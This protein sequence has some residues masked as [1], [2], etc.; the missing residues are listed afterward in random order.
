MAVFAVYIE[1]EVKYFGQARPIGNTYHYQTLPGQA[2]NDAGVVAEVVA[3]EKAILPSSV[4]FREARTWGP[5][6][7]EAFDNV[8]RETIPLS[9]VGAFTEPTSLYREAC[10]L[11]VWPLPRSPVTNRR[12]WLR[13]FMRLAVASTSMSPSV[14]AG[15]DPIPETQRQYLIDT[16]ADA[17]TEVGGVET[18]GLCTADG[19]EP[20]GPPEV[21]PYYYTRQIGQ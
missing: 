9:G 19:A 12:R 20:E 11:F 8:M 10:V 7:G 14:I 1:K 16:Y 5:T 15:I 6:D 4:T 3:A 17:V 21:R 18:I 13:K 2:F